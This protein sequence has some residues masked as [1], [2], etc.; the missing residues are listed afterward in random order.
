MNERR[1]DAAIFVVTGCL[2]Q[3]YGRELEKT[4]P[5]VDLF[6]GIDDIPL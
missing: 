5:E 6:L 1:D 2:P 4:L 3:R